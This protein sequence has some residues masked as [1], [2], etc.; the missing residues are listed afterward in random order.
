MTKEKIK[1]TLNTHG[2]ENINGDDLEYL[3]NQNFDNAIDLLIYVSGALE[4]HEKFKKEL[5]SIKAMNLNNDF[6]S[7]LSQETNRYM[8]STEATHITDCEKCGCKLYDCDEAYLIN[9]YYYC[10]DCICDFKVDLNELREKEE[11]EII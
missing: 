10:E 1:D 6:D 5:R 3:S 11:R 8:E 9:D 7:Y 2:I 4:N